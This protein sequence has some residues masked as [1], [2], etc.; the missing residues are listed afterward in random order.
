MSY[1]GPYTA[2]IQLQD[3]DGSLRTVT[4][5]VNSGSYCTI[6]LKDEFD[7]KFPKARLKALQEH[8]YAYGGVPIKQFRLLL[9]RSKTERALL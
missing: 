2:T 6:L 5:E 4:G 8:S 7:L 9:D 3:A 1:P